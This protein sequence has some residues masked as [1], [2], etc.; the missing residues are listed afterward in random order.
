L[1]FTKT[2]AFPTNEKQPTWLGERKH[3]LQVFEHIIEITNQSDVVNGERYMRGEK[4]N[5]YQTSVIISIMD[6]VKKDE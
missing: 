6:Y 5:K 3:V 4:T 2:C 1:L